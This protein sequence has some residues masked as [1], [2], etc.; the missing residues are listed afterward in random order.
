MYYFCYARSE[1]A[2]ETA[3]EILSYNDGEVIESLEGFATS[4]D[5]VLVLIFPIEAAVRIVAE[6]AM[7][8]TN[9]YSVLCVLPDCSAVMVMKG[10]SEDA[11]IAYNAAQQISTSTEATLLSTSKDSKDFAPDLLKTVL[12]YSIH[13]SDE[14]IFEQLRQRVLSGER[15]DIYSN[16]RLRFSDVALDMTSF[17][18]HSFRRDAGKDFVQACSSA[19][20]SD[21]PTL[22][23]TQTFFEKEI[24]KK[25]T[26]AVILTP[27]TIVLGIEYAGRANSEYSLNVVLEGLRRHA[28]NPLS[29]ATIAVSESAA[30]DD[31]TKLIQKTLKAELKTCEN[32]AINAYRLPLKTGFSLP[33]AE[34]DICTACACT[35]CKNGRILVR[36]SGDKNGLMFSAVSAIDEIKLR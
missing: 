4:N 2:L 18:L 35:V 1:R 25:C 14:A 32:S 9:D 33:Q 23:V 16:M 22:I 15:I 29:V 10:C 13:V 27:R 3:N 5:G 36:R 20:A 6:N 34:A 31:T 17:N 11:S 7:N 21:K 8:S 24:L 30:M 12:A 28:I 26:N 19:I